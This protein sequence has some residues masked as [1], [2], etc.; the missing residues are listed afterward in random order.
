MF[1]L[2]QL[3]RNEDANHKVLKIYQNCSRNL[4]PNA[5][6]VYPSSDIEHHT[7]Q[8]LQKLIYLYL[9]TDCFMKISLQSL[10]QISLE[11]IC[12]DE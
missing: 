2:V 3:T 11:G 1:W 9:F 8:R 6:M 7:V 10:V 4:A 12:S 5:F